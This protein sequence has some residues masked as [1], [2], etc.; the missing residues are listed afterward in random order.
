[1]L[2]T[3]SLYTGAACDGEEP[4][5]VPRAVATLALLLAGAMPLELQ[6]AIPAAERTVLTNFFV[7]TQIIGWTSSTNWCDGVCPAPGQTTIYTFNDPG[8]ECTWY[9]ITCDATQSHVISIDLGSNALSG[10]ITSLSDLTE[11]EGFDVHDNAL[12]NSIP[13]LAGL[14]HLRYFYAYKNLLTGSIPPLA[15]L[16]A[17]RISASIRTTFPA[18]FRCSR[19]SRVFN[20][21]W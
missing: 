13:P 18:A 9:G 19:A 17:C 6:A 3:L 11:L 15:G 7:S 12:Y 2:L 21:S 10:P 5:I 20:C 1:M 14:T 4:G 8:T 16:R